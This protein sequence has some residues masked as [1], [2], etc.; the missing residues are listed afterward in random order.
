MPQLWRMAV[1]WY[2]TRLDPEARRPAPE[3]IRGIFEGI[4]L[5]G[6]FWDAL[7]KS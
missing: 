6:D 7:A 3:E 1:V 2:G 4:G 5:Y